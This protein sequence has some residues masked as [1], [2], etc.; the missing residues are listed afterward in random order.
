MINVNFGGIDFN[1]MNLT[2]KLIIGETEVQS[3]EL[4]L[5]YQ[6]MMAQCQ[7]LVNQ[8]AQDHRPMKVEMIGEKC[9]DLPNGDTVVKPSKLIY[10]NKAYINNFDLNKEK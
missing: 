9:I 6:I 7:E 2:I 10:A 8:V 4:Q 3:Q 5:P 1:V